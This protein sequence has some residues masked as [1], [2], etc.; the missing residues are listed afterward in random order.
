MRRRVS[1]SSIPL[2]PPANEPGWDCADKSKQRKEDVMRQDRLIWKAIAAGSLVLAMGGCRKAAAPELQTTT[3]VQP[4]M[5]PMTVTGCLKSGV[6]D[7]TFVLMAS[8]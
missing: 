5:E 4:R 3:G 7:N 2:G 8:Q 6:A 1:R